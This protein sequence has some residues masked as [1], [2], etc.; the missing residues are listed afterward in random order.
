MFVGYVS[1]PAAI[2]V[3]IKADGIGGVYDIVTNP[4]FQKRGIGT[5]MTKIAVEHLKR[6]N[7]TLLVC[8]PLAMESAFIKNGFCKLW[9]VQSLFQQAQGD[10]DM[11]SFFTSLQEN[12]LFP[13]E[14]KY[15]HGA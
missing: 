11:N 3:G 2:C 4:N 12:V 7:V 5:L 13:A 9:W 6:K 14:L 1:K 15:G 10:L 8:K